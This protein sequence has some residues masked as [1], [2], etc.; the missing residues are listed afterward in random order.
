MV[1]ITVLLML[2]T[3]MLLIQFNAAFIRTLA[4]FGLNSA[5]RVGQG[6]ALVIIIF[7]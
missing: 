7:C 6:C 5:V 3:A 4:C 1:M 2:T